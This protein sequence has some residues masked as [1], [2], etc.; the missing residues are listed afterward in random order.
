MQRPRRGGAC[1]CLRREPDA[2][3][4]RSL[5][6]SPRTPGLRTVR[7]GGG[8]VSGSG[9]GEG[10]CKI[11][12]APRHEAEGRVGLRS[13]AASRTAVR[14][15]IAFDRSIDRCVVARRLLST[16]H[17]LTGNRHSRASATPAAPA[18]LRRRTCGLPS[19][20]TLRLTLAPVVGVSGPFL[21]VLPPLL[22]RHATWTIGPGR[23]LLNAR[24]ELLTARGCNAPDMS[25]VT[26][27][28][29]SCEFGSRGPAPGPP[30]C[31]GLDAALASPGQGWGSVPKVTKMALS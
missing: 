18:Q 31:R 26:S 24:P 27:C 17:Q 12:T 6:A 28:A 11:T 10:A 3:R 8:G 5:R 4:R 14:R 19:R 23:S 15:V 20:R 2:S 30:P 7:L 9:R 22:G 25:A 1:S 29:P 13:G 16:C 21:P